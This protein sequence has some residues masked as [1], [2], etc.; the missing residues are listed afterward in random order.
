MDV[1]VFRQG[2]GGGGCMVSHP[3]KKSIINPN[4]MWLYAIYLNGI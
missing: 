4:L 3:K 1:S 2:A